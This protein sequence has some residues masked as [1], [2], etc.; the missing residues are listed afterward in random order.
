MA[1]TSCPLNRL[2]FSKLFYS[3]RMPHPRDGEILEPRIRA[4]SRGSHGM[5]QTF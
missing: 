1:Y 2:R 3:N 5:D 4:P